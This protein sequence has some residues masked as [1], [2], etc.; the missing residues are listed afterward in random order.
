MVIVQLG[1][2]VMLI[3]PKDKVVFIGDSITDCGRAQ[4]VGEG[5][6]DPLGRGY[7][8][9]VEA[10][11][12][13]TYPGHFIRVVNVG[14]SGHTVR[15]LAARWDRD[16]VGLRP[17]WVSVVIGINDV[18]RQFD[19]PRQP[20]LHVGLEEY[21]RTYAALLERTRP[22]LKGLVLGTPFYVE[23]VR[24]D[25]MRVRMEQY[26]GVVRRLAVRFDARLVDTQA[27]FDRML[28]KMHSANIAWDRVHPNQAGHMAI[29]RAWLD[30]VGYEWGAK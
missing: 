9:Q 14:T 18:W 12:T 10:L 22:S 30:A 8:A 4:P 3:D 16:V 26:A 29:A 21:E 13:S 15:D 11:L 24:E 20:E 7:V 19:S 5:L 23:A 25:A 17:D 1:S 28:A 27:A 6:F 2:Q